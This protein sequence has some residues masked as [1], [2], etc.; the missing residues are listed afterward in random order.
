MYITINETYN[1]KQKTGY[2]I[3]NIDT[4]CITEIKNHHT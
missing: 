2:I 4:W 1:M 3:K